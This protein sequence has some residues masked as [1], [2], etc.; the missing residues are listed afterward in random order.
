MSVVFD[1]RADDA[2]AEEH[3][4]LNAEVVSAAAE[5]LDAIGIRFALSEID[6]FYG[7]AWHALISAHQAREL[8]V[9]RATFLIDT[10]FRRAVDEFRTANPER[11]LDP[12]VLEALGIQ[13]PLAETA[14]QQRELAAAAKIL[15][16]DFSQ[17]ELQPAALA[18]IHGL[19]AREIESALGVPEQRVE[20][21]VAQVEAELGAA[22][23]EDEVVDEAE[24]CAEQASLINRFALGAFDPRSDQYRDAV[25]HLKGCEACCAHAVRARA[26]AA[27][28][29]PSGQLLAALTG[30]SQLPGSSGPAQG[31]P[32]AAAPIATSAAAPSGCKPHRDSRKLMIGIIVAALLFFAGL[33]LFGSDRGDQQ[34]ASTA[35]VSGKSASEKSK[36]RAA[37]A[38]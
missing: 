2:V 34:T 30:S 12:E 25:R 38:H 24:R 6:V 19:P 17:R 26:F 22:F 3:L 8:P 21:V 35:A 10:T 28:V 27:V 7:Q 13:N 18:V 16:S 5:R 36:A 32:R 4:R 15:R 29:I 20:V 11:G 37:R 1:P 33:S 9:D 31:A 23:E 14:E